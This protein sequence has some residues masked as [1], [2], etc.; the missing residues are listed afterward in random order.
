MI[1]N[2]NETGTHNYIIVTYS[3]LLNMHATITYA[4]GGKL[5]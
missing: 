2:F 1:I 5:T 4:M 3:L